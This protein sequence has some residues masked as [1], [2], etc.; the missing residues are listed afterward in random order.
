MSETVKQES[1]QET[2]ARANAQAIEFIGE[3]LGVP[4][5]VHVED[6]L[7]GCIIEA[8]TWIRIGDPARALAILEGALLL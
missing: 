8:A 7:R 1:M 2:C 4:L 5:V 6:Q 3:A